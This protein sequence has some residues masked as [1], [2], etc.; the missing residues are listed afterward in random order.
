[1]RILLLGDSGPLSRAIAEG[2]SEA[3]NDVTLLGLRAPW[4]RELG[5]TVITGDRR[6]DLGAFEADAFNVVVDLT[7]YLPSTVR[8]S[9]EAFSQAGHYIFLSSTSVYA[10]WDQEELDEF[11][12]L[13]HIEPAEA[14]A[15]KDPRDIRAHQYGPLKALCEGEVK[16]RFR[17]RC[18]LIR[19]GLQ[20]GPDDPSG[21]FTYWVSRVADGGEVL[22]PGTGRDLVQFVDH[23]D[24]GGFIV[25]CAE[26][27]AFGPYNVVGP[28]HPLTFEEFLHG[29]KCASG[30]DAEFVW[31]SEAF[32]AENDVRAWV[33][34][35]MW[36][37][38]RRASARVSPNRALRAGLE[39]RAPGETIADTLAWFTDLPS[40]DRH[41]D[42]A[43][44]G[45]TRV[46]EAELIRAWRERG[47]ARAGVDSP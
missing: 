10:E 12:A 41:R 31:A 27:G 47:G 1:M 46:H 45:L 26:A 8:L 11:S 32:L 22:A 3:G 21:R 33:E 5:V 20:C 9:T 4:A 38:S 6:R 35:P 44:V 19:T 17:D 13:A 40:G 36:L 37:P 15:I 25:R 16:Q 23:R 7:G 14:E 28:R 29:C 18:T 2:A 42:F 39:L 43:G 34:M 30:S 24:L